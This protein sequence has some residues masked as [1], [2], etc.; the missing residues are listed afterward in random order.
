MKS[1]T[2]TVTFDKDNIVIVLRY[3]PA[4]VCDVCGDYTIEDTI[5]KSLLQTTKDERAKGHEISILNYN[6]AA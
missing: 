2:T 3:V 1:G 5:A 4:K 6:K